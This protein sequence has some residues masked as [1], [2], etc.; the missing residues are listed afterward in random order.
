MQHLEDRLHTFL[1]EDYLQRTHGETG[2]APQAR[3]EAG[4]FLPQLPASQEQLDL[5]LLTVAKSRQVRQDG[6]YFHGCRYIDLTLAAF[7]GE[8]V[9]IR[10]DPC[11]MAEIRVFH[12][13][14]FLCRAVCQELAGET[15]SLQEVVQARKAR[16]GHLRADLST[17]EA[18]VEAFLAAHQVEE[19]PTEPSPTPDPP[20]PRLK[21][22]FNE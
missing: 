18:V 4:G 14:T 16:L 10:Y 19:P 8:S 7:V 13:D 17:R 3:W 2:M 11:D 5:L 20:R 12:R 21:R 6:I 9:I 15:I 22:Y 1:I